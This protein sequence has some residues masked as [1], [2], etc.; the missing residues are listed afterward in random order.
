MTSPGMDNIER[1]LTRLGFKPKRER[2]HVLWHHSKDRQSL[3]IAVTERNGELKLQALEMSWNLETILKN[4]QLEL[5]SLWGRSIKISHSVTEHQQVHISVE[6]PEKPSPAKKT[7]PRSNPPTV[8]A[9]SFRLTSEDDQLKLFFENFLV[10]GLTAQAEWPADL[11]QSISKAIFGK[12]YRYAICRSLHE[13]ECPL[14][15]ACL[16]LIDSK[17]TPEDLVALGELMQAQTP[18]FMRGNWNE[19]ATT[20]AYQF[21]LDTEASQEDFDFALNPLAQGIEILEARAAGESIRTIDYAIVNRKHDI[22]AIKGKTTIAFKRKLI[23]FLQTNERLLTVDEIESCINE[24]TYSSSRGLAAAALMRIY[25]EDKQFE[26]ALNALK[27]WTEVARQ[28]HGDLESITTFDVAL[29]EFAGMCLATISP[30]QSIK[31]FERALIN[32]DEP[33]I[34]ARM[35]EILKK[36]GAPEDELNLLDRW[37]RVEKRLDQI[38]LIITRQVELQLSNNDSANAAKNLEI[39]VVKYSEHI[40]QWLPFVDELADVGQPQKALAILERIERYLSQK[41]DASAKD[42]ISVNASI[43]RIWDYH[44]DRVD[45]AMPRYA[46]ILELSEGVDHELVSAAENALERTGDHGGSLSHKIKRWQILPDESRE[47]FQDLAL[48]ILQQARELGDIETEFTVTIDLLNMKHDVIGLT[49]RVDLWMAHNLPWRRLINACKTLYSH[50]NVPFALARKLSNIARS[51]LDDH[52]LA[53][54]LLLQP[55]H[56]N[57]INDTEFNYLL[58]YLSNEHRNT[59]VEAIVIERLASVNADARVIA[60]K[61]LVKHTV[62]HDNDSIQMALFE[63]WLDRRDPTLLVERWASLLEDNSL[64]PLA[65]SLL[66]LIEENLAATPAIS[67]LVSELIDDTLTYPPE[68]VDHFLLSLIRIDV[69]I[70]ENATPNVQKAANLAALSTNPQAA[71]PYLMMLLD[72]GIPIDLPDAMVHRALAGESELL[73]KFNMQRIAADQTTDKAAYARNAAELI[74]RSEIVDAYT[75]PVIEQLIK[76]EIVEPDDISLMRTFAKVLRRPKILVDSL[77][78]C[79]KRSDDPQTTRTYELE[80]ANVAQSELRDYAFAYD[81][82]NRHVDTS[83]PSLE[84][85]VLAKIALLAG[86]PERSSQIILEILRNPDCVQYPDLVLESC[87]LLVDNKADRVLVAGVLQTL[88]SWSE[89]QEIPGLQNRMSDFAIFEGFATPQDVSSALMAALSRGDIHQ[90]AAYMIKI[91]E[92]AEAESESLIDIVSSTRAIVIQL[93][94]EN[95]WWQL[96]GEMLHGEFNIRVSS[97][98]RMELLCQYGLWLYEQDGRQREALT[99]LLLLT[100]ENPKDERIWMPVYIILEELQEFALQVEHLE[101]IIPRIEKDQSVLSNYPIHLE[102]L[103][104]SLKRAKERINGRPRSKLSFQKTNPTGA[105]FHKPPS[106]PTPS[107]AIVAG[108]SEVGGAAANLNQPLPEPEQVPY[109]NPFAAIVVQPSAPSEEET[110]FVQNAVVSESVVAPHDDAP[111][112]EFVEP[113]DVNSKNIRFSN[114]EESFRPPVNLD[115]RSLANNL[116]APRDAAALLVH[117]AFASEAEKHLAIQVAALLCGDMPSLDIWHWRVWRESSE[118]DY[119]LSGKDR[120]PKLQDLT[121]LNSPVHRFLNVFSPVLARNYRERFTIADHIRSQDP[122]A[123]I[124][125]KELKLSDPVLQRTGLRHH[126]KRIEQARLTFFDTPDAQDEVFLDPTNRGI[127]FSADVCGAKPPGYLMHRTMALIWAMQLQYHVILRTDARREIEPLYQ[128]FLKY[129]RSTPLE[130]IRLAFSNDTGKIQKLTQGLNREKLTALSQQ[131]GLISVQNI[132]DLQADMSKH[133]YRILLA[134]SLDLIGIF[135]ALT[136]E[137]VTT[138]SR[139]DILERIRKSPIL[140]DLFSF[141]TKLFL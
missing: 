107:P 132:Q 7:L 118:F 100:R 124:I 87:R 31:A 62:V 61:Y 134:E 95:Y 71:K 123:R 26:K 52:E 137:I 56:G 19:S 51:K 35:A 78:I 42:K 85:L 41:K 43:A 83:Q 57:D 125:M 59:E 53:V 66:R 73:V 113:F 24:T 9:W 25:Y 121:Q 129:G 16:N 20:W 15:Y 89:V 80:A 13:F 119:P 69:E 106:D 68:A 38:E 48:Q 112:H 22:P 109:E 82:L 27:I 11:I 122:S 90:S 39:L 104:A 33:R 115:W 1:L 139:Q 93:G 81:I 5:A 116:E 130:R 36:H 98:I 91:F 131:A 117:T 70:S 50:S 37:R 47:E 135:E 4:I 128:M 32:N 126:G 99:S 101:N 65:E 103:K 67:S 141:A 58:D 133:I 28:A 136:G 63:D 49:E 127:H 54:Q 75:V 45:L 110:P 76:S 96:I 97:K 23:R 8:I 72:R 74:K 77:L 94:F 60:L 3:S 84:V 64:H 44:L 34:F 105:A 92:R 6:I 30:E 102:T 17:I 79:A 114:E 138:L 2:S 18:T 140:V 108:F 111:S 46:M 40:A 14:T 86:N 120:L 29:P 55:H 12:S 10:L 21:K 88:I